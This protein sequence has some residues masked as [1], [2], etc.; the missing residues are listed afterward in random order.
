[1]NILQ[2]TVIVK[3]QKFIEDLTMENGM[4]IQQ[5]D[6][7]KLVEEAIKLFKEEEN[8]GEDTVTTFEDWLSSR[9]ISILTELKEPAEIASRHARKVASETENDLDTILN[10]L[11]ERGVI[12]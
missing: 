4:S 8:S 10:E 2:A 5:V 7:L 6:N 9:L 1:M 11:R 3:T 12:E